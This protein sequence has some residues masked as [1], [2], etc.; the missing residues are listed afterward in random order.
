MKFMNVIAKFTGKNDMINFRNKMLDEAEAL[1]NEGKMD[2]YNAKM[3]DIKTFDDEYEQYTEN[4]ANIEAMKG[5]V[6]VKNML[7]DDAK[8]GIV[9]AVRVSA[10]DTDRAYRNAFAI[11]KKLS[12]NNIFRNPF[13]PIP[14]LRNIANSRL[15]KA[16]EV[17]VVL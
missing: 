5:A 6:S 9:D 13:G 3:E 7:T 1:L 17:T 4:K 15:R 11:K 14:T 2:E 10:E 12:K 16:K 8:N